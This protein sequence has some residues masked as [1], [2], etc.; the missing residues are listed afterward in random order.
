MVP[1][2]TDSET[3]TP[4]VPASMMR[5]CTQVWAQTYFLIVRV[6]DKRAMHLLLPYLQ[7]RI[8]ASC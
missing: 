3:G 1:E 6:L 5:R 2:A 7:S 4:M 8:E